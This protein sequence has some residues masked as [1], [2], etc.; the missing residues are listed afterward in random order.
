VGKQ[1]RKGAP[2]VK[3]ISAQLQL[4]PREGGRNANGDKR[5]I[6]SE[7]I[8]RGVFTQWWGGNCEG[9]KAS[10]SEGGG[11]LGF[12]LPRRKSK[13]SGIRTFALEPDDARGDRKT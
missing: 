3:E 12:A 8:E 10:L 9:P 13:K 1:A 2:C 11:G 4:G 6:Y 7:S 5:S